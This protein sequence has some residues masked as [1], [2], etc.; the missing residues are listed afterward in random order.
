MS[1]LSGRIRVLKRRE[2]QVVGCAS[3]GG[4]A[5]H[6]LKSEEGMPPWLDGAS[7]CRTCGAGVKVYDRDMW[8]GLP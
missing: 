7:C 5:F 2:R 1:R 6:V 3:C 8:E 4:Q